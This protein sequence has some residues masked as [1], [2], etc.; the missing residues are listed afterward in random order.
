MSC[1]Q[2][3]SWKEQLREPTTK[4]ASPKSADSDTGF[5]T[6]GNAVGGSSKRSSLANAIFGLRSKD[7]DKDKDRRAAAD[8]SGSELDGSKHRDHAVL[9]AV[10]AFDTSR[11]NSP[12]T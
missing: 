11:N 12:G 3:L 10:S 2:K 1:P 7:K 8:A 9:S 4:L 5:D 6:A